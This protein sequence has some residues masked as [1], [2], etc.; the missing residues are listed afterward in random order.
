MLLELIG[1][2]LKTRLVTKLLEASSMNISQMPNV[3]EG[4]DQTGITKGY[5]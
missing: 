2:T 5:S 4:T 3:C 1:W